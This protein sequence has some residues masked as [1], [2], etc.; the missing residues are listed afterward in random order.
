MAA[1]DAKSQVVVQASAYGTGLE[2][3]LLPEVLNDLRQD[4]KAIGRQDPLKTATVL[5]DSGYHSEVT[6]QALADAK[7]G[8]LVAD[9]G[10]RSREPRFADAYRHKPEDQ[11]RE[12]GERRSQWFQPK[13]FTFDAEA[14]TC[15]CPA[16][17]ALKLAMLDA[18]TTREKPR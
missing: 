11:Q 15:R 14:R 10:F 17:K 6:L 1:V 12:P 18:P 13:D 4:F 5:T 2:N 8:A 16:D 7:V 9:T 3:A